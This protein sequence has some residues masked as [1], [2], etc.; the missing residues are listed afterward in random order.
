MTENIARNE[1]DVTLKGKKYSIREPNIDELTMFENRVKSD[2]LKMFMAASGDIELKDRIRMVADILKEPMSANDIQAELTTLSGVRYML[3]LVM[4][5]N[6]D[7]TEDD[8][9]SI[10]DLSNLAE[11]SAILDGLGADDSSEVPEENPQPTSP[12]SS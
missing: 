4:R 10:V 5:H 6:P 1:I 8:M 2:R 7:I 12:D 3:Y 9:G 11:V